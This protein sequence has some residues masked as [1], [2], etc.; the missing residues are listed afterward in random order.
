M[1]ARNNR[2]IQDKW[3]WKPDQ[4]RTSSGTEFQL[5]T[6]TGENFGWRKWEW[7]NSWLKKIGRKKFSFKRFRVQKNVGS[8]K[9][10]EVKFFWGQ[11]NFWYKNLT[12]QKNVGSNKLWVQRSIWSKKI[13]VLINFRFRKMSGQN[14]FESKNLLDNC[15]QDKCGICKCLRNRPKTGVWQ[16]L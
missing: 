13:V 12:V 10:F 11:N 14:N 3:Y 5:E 7:K 6:K 2:V 16:K 1:F 8:K 15:H 4:N 9:C